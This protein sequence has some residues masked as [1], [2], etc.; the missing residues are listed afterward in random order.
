[1]VHFEETNNIGDVIE[2]YFP[3]KLLGFIT[4]NGT[5]EAVVQCSVNPLHWD[6]MKLNFIVDIELELN[7]D[8]LFIFVPIESIVHPLCVIPDNSDQTNR[9]L[10]VLP[11]QSWSRSFGNN[12]SIDR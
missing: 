4:T 1:M 11:K 6:D 8:V 10:N 7:F 5:R 9:Y 3:S 2:T 12:I